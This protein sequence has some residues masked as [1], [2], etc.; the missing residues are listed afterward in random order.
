MEKKG[1]NLETVFQSAFKQHVETPSPKVLS[2]LK[3]RLWFSDFFSFKMNKPNVVY[4]TILTGA[5]VAGFLYFNDNPDARQTDKLPQS[6]TNETINKSSEIIPSDKKTN[7]DKQ[8]I[9]SNK[10]MLAAY[11][12]VTNIKGCAPL[13]VKFNAQSDPSTT[14]AWD[15]GNGENSDKQNPTYTYAK[16]GTYLAKLTITNNEGNTDSFSKEIQVFET[17][18]AKG[19]IDIEKSDNADR[20]VLFVNK[21]IGSNSH[22]WSFG[23][24]KIANIENPTHTYDE[25]GVYHVK[26][27]ASSENGCRDTTEIKNLFIK[28]NYHLIFP[29]TFKP[30]TSDRGNNGYYESNGAQSAIFYPKNYGTKEYHLS[31][32]T[33][34]G[35]E[36]FSTKNIKQGW[37]GYVRGR[38]APGG[39]YSYSAKGIYPNG[40]SFYIE[41][42]VKI[43]IED[44]FQD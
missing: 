13:Q 4:T 34:N 26:L 12:D 43:I 21:S 38:I 14:Y 24:T 28:N 35:I 41:G 42:K 23:D 44:Y 22:Q 20:K 19:I 16:P 3:F 6:S 29:Y 7:V 36:V 2:R 25:Y 37:N 8:V 30:N 17:P 10:E 15:F 39:V 33:S 32:K 18:V 40:K 27:I 9:N 1:N 31:I 11:F 5:I